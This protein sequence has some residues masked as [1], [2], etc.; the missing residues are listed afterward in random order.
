MINVVGPYKKTLGAILRY[1]QLGT[2]C[3]Y[4]ARIG[5]DHKICLNFMEDSKQEYLK[6]DKIGD[7]IRVD[8]ISTR[9]KIGE[10]DRPK[11]RNTNYQNQETWKKKLMSDCLLASFLGMNVK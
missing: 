1:E 11:N 10:E 6:E 5:H 4:C 2:V 8:Q 3:T 9:V 7:W